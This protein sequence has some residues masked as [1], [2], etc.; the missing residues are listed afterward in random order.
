VKGKA[1]YLVAIFA[2][3]RSVDISFAG[4][5][6][7]QRTTKISAAWMK[8]RQLHVQFPYLMWM[9]LKSVLKSLLVDQE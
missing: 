8:S 1:Y 6:S 4:S 9:V 3:P 2:L 5:V 7:L